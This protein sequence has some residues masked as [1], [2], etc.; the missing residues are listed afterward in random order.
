METHIQKEKVSDKPSLVLHQAHRYVLIV[1]TDIS[2]KLI[3][4]IVI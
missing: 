4:L 2:L 3:Q 1:K